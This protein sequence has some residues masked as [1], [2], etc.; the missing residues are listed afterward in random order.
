MYEAGK[1]AQVAIE[2]KRYNIQVLGLGDTKWIQS[3]QM[4]LAMR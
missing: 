1:T 3:G 2:M 4:R